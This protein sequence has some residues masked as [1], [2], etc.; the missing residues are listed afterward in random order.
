M[1]VLLCFL[2]SLIVVLQL[3]FVWVHTAPIQKRG[4]DAMIILGFQCDGD[5]IHPL[6]LERLTAALELL[7]IADYKKIILTGGRV[8]ST[9]SE[10]EIMKEFLISRAV[11]KERII[12]E[13][14]AMDTIENIRNCQT[15]LE[16]MNL[17]TCT[18]ISNSF[19][20]RRTQ[21]IAS[22]MGFSSFYYANRSLWALYRQVYRTLHELKAF[23]TTYKLLRSM[24][25]SKG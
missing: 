2:I 6:L 12:L 13:Q 24:S 17:R 16:K 9:Q 21:Y 7:K 18:V 10:A 22:Y 5:Q 8:T 14:A 25:K 11:D 20:I 3:F 1:T 15:I 19:H 4:T 23:A